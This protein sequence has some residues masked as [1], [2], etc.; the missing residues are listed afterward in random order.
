MHANIALATLTLMKNFQDPL[1]YVRREI[2]NALAKEPAK[3]FK[4]SC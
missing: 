3:E 1:N 4:G 2:Q